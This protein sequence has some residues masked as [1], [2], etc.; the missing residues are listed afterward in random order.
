MQKKKLLLVHF[1]ECYIFSVYNKLYPASRVLM[2]LKRINCI[3]LYGC[4]FHQCFFLHWRSTLMAISKHTISPWKIQNVTLKNHAEKVEKKNNSKK[5]DAKI[6]NLLWKTRKYFVF[7]LLYSKLLVMYNVY[8]FWSN[9]K[10]NLRKLSGWFLT[11][12]PVIKKEHDQAKSWPQ[13]Y[14]RVI[15]RWCLLLSFPKR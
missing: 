2:G 1:W 7:Y 15:I 6:L 11:K 12:N 8:C 14:C 9:F 10:N 4:K 3:I 5:V 13:C